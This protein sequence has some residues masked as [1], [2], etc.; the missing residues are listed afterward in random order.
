M[1]VAEEEDMFKHMTN[2]KFPVLV[3]KCVDDDFDLDNPEH[4]KLFEE[5]F[6]PQVCDFCHGHP[7]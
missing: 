1:F 4:M 7:A 6:A 3:P 5:Q 2:D